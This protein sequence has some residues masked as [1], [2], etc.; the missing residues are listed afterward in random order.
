MRTRQRTRQPLGHLHGTG[1]RHPDALKKG[2]CCPLAEWF[3]Y[4]EVDWTYWES[5]LKEWGPLLAGAL[6]GAG[7]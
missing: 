5:K 7:K 3:I 2:T 1:P 4:G 6:M